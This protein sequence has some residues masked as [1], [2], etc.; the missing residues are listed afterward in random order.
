MIKVLTIEDEEFYGEFLKKIIQKRYNCDLARDANQAKALLKKNQYDVILYDLRLPGDLGKNLVEYVRE[1]ID[2]DIINIIVTGYE[3]DWP[4]VETTA[5]N[6]FYYLKKGSFKP[7]E[8]IKIVDN[9]VQL[10]KLKLKEKNYLK[11]LII[12]ERLASTGKLAISIAH[13]INN[14]LQGIILMTE[15]LREKT[16]NTKDRELILDDINLLE[17]GIERIRNVVKILLDLNRIEYEEEIE[18]NLVNI[19]ERVI[20]FLRPIAKEKNTKIHVYNSNQDNKIIISEGQ[21]FHVLFYI[22]T[23]LLE[24]SYKSI[25]IALKQLN[26]YANIEITTSKKDSKTVDISHISYIS[27]DFDADNL[28]MELSKKIINN[29]NGTVDFKKIKDGEL[30]TIRLPLSKDHQT[31]EVIIY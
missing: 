5:Q 17:K 8:L 26:N 18:D 28:R 14:P 23:N 6:I 2:P 24:N 13:E 15:L 1:K 25:E 29:Y 10:R 21:T 19:V 11:N 20:S 30:I 22:F 12:S 16:G 4:P 3:N 27:H 9:A 7:E 31:N